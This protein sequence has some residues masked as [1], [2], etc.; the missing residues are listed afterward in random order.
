MAVLKLENRLI[1]MLD[2]LGFSNQIERAENLEKIALR[3]GDIILASKKRAFSQEALPGSPE[4]APSNFAVGEFVFDNVVL[5]SEEISPK[6]VG[7]FVFSLIA[8]MEMFYAAGFPLRGA[9]S[10]GD[11]YS[12]DENG[13]FLSN[14]FKRLNT[15]GQNQNWTGCVVLPEAE[16]YVAESLL[17]TFCGGTSNRSDALIRYSVPAKPG[18]P[19]FGELYCLNWQYF[20]TP[21]Q[22]EEGLR[23]LSGNLEKHQCT[24]TFIEYLGSLPD[25]VQVL[26]EQFLPATSVRF[27]KC[28]FSVRMRFEDHQG[29]AVDPGCDFLISVNGNAERVRI[30]RTKPRSDPF[31]GQARCRR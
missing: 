4:Q 5:V 26:P 6:S 2:V 21:S 23:F 7:N 1:A 11:D 14:V 9:I 18:V 24:A 25:P 27:M 15:V 31:V 19:D 8:I 17:G 22:T 20:L 29:N 10:I 30:D 28:R 16:A 13:V 3:Y 12:N